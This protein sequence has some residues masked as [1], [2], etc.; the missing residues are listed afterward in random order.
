MKMTIVTDDQGEILGAIPGDT[1]PEH[2]IL[3][4]FQ[5]HIVEVPDDT[6]AITDGAELKKRLQEALQAQHGKQ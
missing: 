3:K 5:S 1:V 4:D 6:G 2:V